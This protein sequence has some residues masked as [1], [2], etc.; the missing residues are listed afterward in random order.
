MS[1]DYNKWEEELRPKVE[2]HEFAFD[3]S[4]WEQMDELLGE[5]GGTMAPKDKLPPKS[6]RLYGWIF[7][8]LVLTI[9]GVLCWWMLRTNNEN[10]VSLSS[11]NV[12]ETLT[13]LPSENQT[14]PENAPNIVEAGSTTNLNDRLSLS[15]NT[16]K[17]VEATPEPVNISP[18]TTS[19]ET[20][21]EEAPLLDRSAAYFTPPLTPKTTI[22]LLPSLL[23]DGLSTPVLNS[24]KRKRDRRTLYPD[25]IERY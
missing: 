4:A 10:T 22:P 18:T 20:L 2:A 15:A 14:P 25:V 3:P 12:T 8:G 13:D 23:D 17:L 24:Q 5:G 9:I 21:P 16:P 11:F 19:K 6:G 1:F 7:K